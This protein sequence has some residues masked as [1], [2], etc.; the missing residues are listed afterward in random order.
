MTSRINSSEDLGRR[1]SRRILNQFFTTQDYPYTRHHIDSYD[2]F[3]SRD[4]ISIFQ[5]QNPVRLVKERVRDTSK[6]AYNIYW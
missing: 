5:S 4:L 3:L 6:Y 1:V 2:Q